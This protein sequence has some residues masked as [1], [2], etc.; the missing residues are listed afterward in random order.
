MDTL[1][2]V[3]TYLLTYLHDKALYRSTLLYFTLTI[4]VAAGVSRLRKQRQTA[5]KHHVTAVTSRDVER[6]PGDVTT[7]TSQRTSSRRHTAIDN[8]SAQN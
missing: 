8:V 7:L 6:A 3:F 2:V 5:D 4:V 1:I